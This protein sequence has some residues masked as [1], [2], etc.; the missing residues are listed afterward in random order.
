MTQHQYLREIK[1]SRLRCH[2]PVKKAPPSLNGTPQQLRAPNTKREIF[3]SISVLLGFNNNLIF[4]SGF[5]GGLGG[6]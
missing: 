1:R 4:F 3:V 5:G 6:S 2:K